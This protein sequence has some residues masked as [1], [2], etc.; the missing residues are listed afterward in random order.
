MGADR[1]SLGSVLTQRLCWT[2]G[3]VTCQTVSAALLSAAIA[4]C[5]CLIP[6]PGKAQPITPAADGTGTIVTIN[7]NQFV[8]TGGTLSG[9]GA[10]L[11][12]SFGQF[13]L[14]ANQLANF[15]S[16]P[17]IQNILGRIIGGDPSL[18]NG[19]VRVSGGNS[20]LYLMNPAGLVFGP[21]AQ[22]NVPGDFFATTATGIEFGSN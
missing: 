12:H 8:I 4:L 3:L 9:D 17:Q 13:G 19:L 11:F 10:N 7:G 6:E 1:N 5:G 2:P 22:L 21:D 20:N 14:D 15:L 16:N 18:I